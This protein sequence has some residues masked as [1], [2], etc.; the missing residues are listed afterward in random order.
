MRRAAISVLSLSLMLSPIVAWAA[1]AVPPNIAAAVADPGRPA[2]DKARD[3]NR[4]PA[5]IL[6]FAGV[7]P[8]EKVGDYAAGQGYFT[9]LFAAAVG[10]GG[11]VYATVPASLF[12]YQNIVEGI[13]DIDAY[14]KDHANVS[15]TAASALDSARYP[16]K[17]DLFWISQNYHDLKDPF[18]GP[19]D[20]AAF[21]RTVFA[22]L[23]PG[24]TYIVLDHVAAPGSPA[25]V[26]DTLHRIEPSVVR[27]EVEA[28]GFKFVGQSN[29]LANPADP[30]DKG[31]FDASIR[32]RTDQFVLKFRKP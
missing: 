13:A 1:E 22:A 25:D 7:K 29:L 8:G 20:M 31:V 30:H 27:R 21:N 26:T 19:V 16:E 28:A 3:A 14:A 32:G 10:P 6:A 5:E 2:A 9:R 4:K 24:G 23:K 12:Q 11:H 15:V 17:L 18:M